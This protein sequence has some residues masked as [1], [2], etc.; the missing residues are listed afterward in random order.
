MNKF[1]SLLSLGSADPVA[2]QRKASQDLAGV[3]RSSRL[4]WWHDFV[5]LMLPQQFALLVIAPYSRY[6]LALLDILDAGID[7]EPQFPLY[8]ASIEHFLKRINY[9]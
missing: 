3:V 8:V 7:K 2:I 1:Q 5:R 4:R 9:L 6:D